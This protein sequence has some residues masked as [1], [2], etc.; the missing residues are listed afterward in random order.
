MESS[1][2]RVRIPKRIDDLI[3]STVDQGIFTNKTDLVKAALIQYLDN[4]HLLDEIKN[5]IESH[6]IGQN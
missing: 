1:E 3:Q 2:I 6:P 5:S 4:L